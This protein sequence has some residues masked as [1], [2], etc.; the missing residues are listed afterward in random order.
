MLPE[1]RFLNLSYFYNLLYELLVNG[2]LPPGL[3]RFAETVIFWWG[4]FALFLLPLLWLGIGVLLYRIIALRREESRDIRQI[5]LSR[6]LAAAPP[7][8]NERW[9]KILALLGSE[10]EAEWRMAIIEADNIL[11]E[12]VKKMNYPGETLGDRLKNIEKSDFLTLSDAWEA[13]KLRNQIAH[14]G[15]FVLTKHQTR[16][17]VERYKRVFEEFDYI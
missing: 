7:V 1:P 10:N 11:E 5:S 15:G 13:H 2:R 9:E 12:M 16:L 8:K 17:A 14:E 3:A 4:F 6:S